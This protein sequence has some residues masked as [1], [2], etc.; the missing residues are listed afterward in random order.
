M[1]V[2]ALLALS[3]V[4]FVTA[5]MVS[6]VFGPPVNQVT[7]EAASWDHGKVSLWITLDDGPDTPYI[8]LPNGM[9]CTRL[10]ATTYKLTSGDPSPYFYRVKCD[11][12]YGYVNRNQVR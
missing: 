2:A 7:L 6:D 1:K 3:V 4:L 9:T 5:T 12:R 8:E 11:D 10:N